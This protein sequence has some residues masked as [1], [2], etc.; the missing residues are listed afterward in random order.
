MSSN[1]SWFKRRSLCF[2]YSSVITTKCEIWRTGPWYK[3]YLSEHRP[4]AYV[5]RRNMKSVDP[6]PNDQ[7]LRY[8]K[9]SETDVLSFENKGPTQTSQKIK[10]SPDNKKQTS[11]HF[12]SRRKSRVVKSRFKSRG[13]QLPRLKVS[14]SYLPQIDDLSPVQRCLTTY[15]S[16]LYLL[17]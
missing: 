4:H 5:I 14:S 7:V 13:V 2:A 16:S 11:L 6:M 9:S 8:L 3:T 10:K 17:T 15:Y 1:G 12:S